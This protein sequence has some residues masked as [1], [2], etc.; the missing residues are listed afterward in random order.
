LVA[1]K[2][3]GLHALNCCKNYVWLSCIGFVYVYLGDTPPASD[4]PH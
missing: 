3:L 2:I 1:D 4:V